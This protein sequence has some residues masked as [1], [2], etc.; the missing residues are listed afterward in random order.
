MKQLEN[1]RTDFDSKLEAQ[2]VLNEKYKNDLKWLLV[3][4]I[5][6]FVII[7]IRRNE[8]TIYSYEYTKCIK[9]FNLQTLTLFEQVEPSELKNINT[10]IYQI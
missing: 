3:S 6:I 7:F 1:A 10:G 8:V 4:K 2:R 5:D 9:E